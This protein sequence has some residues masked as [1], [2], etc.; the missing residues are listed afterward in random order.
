[1]ID[2][3]R[4]ATRA[5]PHGLAAPALALTLGLA[6][7]CGSGDQDV[8]DAPTPVATP[9]S[10][11]LALQTFDS[12]W[13]RINA[14]Y[15]DPEFRGID[16]PGIRDELR[17][18]AESAESREDL[19][20][21]LRDM[22][23]RL[24]ES[25]FAILPEESVDAISVDE[26]GIADSEA[27]GDGGPGDLGVEVRWVDGRLTVFRVR[28]GSALEA[29]VAPGW[30]V[31][32]IGERSMER[33]ESVVAEAEPGRARIAVQ[34]E[35]LQGAGSLM[36]GP[37]GSTVDVGLI[38]GSGALRE[39]TLERRPVKGDLVRFGALPA[40]ASWLEYRREPVDGD[41]CVGVIEFNIW[42]AP[43]VTPFNQAVDALD[44]C[45]GIVIDLRGNLGGVG[46]MVMST[47]GSFFAERA[48]LGKVQSR[49]GELNFVAMPRGVDAEGQL[50]DAFEGRLAVLVD[51]MSMSTSE[52]FAAGLKSTGRARLFGQTTP[53][54]ALPAMT[55]RLPSGDVL[56]HVVSNLTDPEGVRIEG[57]GVEPDVEIPLRRDV[58]LEGRDEVLDAAIDWA[59]GSGMQR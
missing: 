32:S 47:A 48:E 2:R 18:A 37:A 28:D 17:P 13:S 52:I 45:A 4:R 21:V 51:R 3:L 57:L 14:S 8:A 53:G 58:L 43:L 10:T 1:M 38:D 39:L 34:T 23:S 25:H 40:M 30:I 5:R 56:Y 44:D 50:R 42:M 7:G 27:E 29:G 9:I 54:Y 22:L 16:W 26:D 31:A 20:R 15:Y 33:W 19:R 46:G 49:S 41:R 6:A 55:I 36:E 59:S 35:T 11:E 24:G 12:A